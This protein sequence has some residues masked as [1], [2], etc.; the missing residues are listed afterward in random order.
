MSVPYRIPGE[1]RLQLERAL[2]EGVPADPLAHAFQVAEVMGILHQAFEAAGFRVV[3]VGGGAIEIHAPGI[4]RSGDLDLGITQLW[5]ARAQESE[6]F[7]QLGFER[8]G[9]HWRQQGLL[10]EVPTAHVSDPTELVNVRGSVFRVV[11]KEA[12]LRDRIV[13]YKHWGV[14]AYGDQAIRMLSAFGNELDWSWLRSELD[15]E[16]SGDA[17]EALL[18][19]Q[20]EAETGSVDL[21]ARLRE[22][23][24]RLKQRPSPPS[25]GA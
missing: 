11:A 10:V 17:L 15:R 6:V 4:Y 18:R 5:E 3:L 2:A 22:E 25:S 1:L 14:T 20:A 16:R 13:G 19:I 24:D 8:I 23:L 7:V 9:R 21:A 12:L